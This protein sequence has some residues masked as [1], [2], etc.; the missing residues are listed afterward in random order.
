MN[1]QIKGSFWL[2]LSLVLSPR[3]GRDKT[4]GC[5]EKFEQIDRKNQ[6]AEKIPFKRQ[7]I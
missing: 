6:Q 4:T 5:V 1:Q 2:Q 3:N 7:I